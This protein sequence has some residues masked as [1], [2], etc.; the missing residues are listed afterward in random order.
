M[1]SRQTVKRT[2]IPRTA[3]NRQGTVVEPVAAAE[4]NREYRRSR[5][6][7]PEG[8]SSRRRGLHEKRRGVPGRREAAD[9]YRGV[10]QAAGVKPGDTNRRRE[11]EERS[12]EWRQEATDAEEESGEEEPIGRRSRSA[13]DRRDASGQPKP[14]VPRPQPTASRRQRNTRPPGPRPLE[15]NNE[16]TLSGSFSKGPQSSQA[17]PKTGCER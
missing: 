13:A 15:R 3:C 4:G 2:R 6:R 1:A 16:E 12:P 10:Q 11:A 7:T 8:L 14:A 5:N 17:K 9:A